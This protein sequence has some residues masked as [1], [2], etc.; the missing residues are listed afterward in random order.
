V[1][2]RFCA[3]GA[4]HQQIGGLD[5]TYG[6]RQ[7]PGGTWCNCQHRRVHCPADTLAEAV[8]T[9]ERQ[10]GKHGPYS[11]DLEK[12]LAEAKLDLRS[13]TNHSAG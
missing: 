1:I 11:P 9:M 6:H 10:R 2:C 8:E 12:V 5:G 3:T 7:C 13:R 4:D